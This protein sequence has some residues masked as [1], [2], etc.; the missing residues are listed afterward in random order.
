M[1]W[2]QFRP[3]FGSEWE[4]GEHMALVAMTQSGKTTLA[5]QLLGVRDFV[6]VFGTKVR[7][8]SLYKPLEAAGYVRKDKWNPWEWEETG[9][10]Y[11]IFAPP[12][13]IGE[14]PDAREVSQ[15]LTKQS[16][17]FRVAMLQIFKSGGWTIYAD[18]VRYLQEELHLESELNLLYLQGASNDISLVAATQRPRSILL[19]AFNMASWFFIWNVA[20]KEDRRRVAEYTGALAAQVFEAAAH[21]P[22]YEFICLN[23]V[24]GAIVR[25]RVEL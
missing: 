16:E 5:R 25:S 17:A 22:R 8:P 9:E 2:G 14:R 10:R 20:D 15:A 19:N 4:P 18:E 21:L 23:K 1:P 11:I 6:V 24:T 3:W 13:E 7:D 12:L